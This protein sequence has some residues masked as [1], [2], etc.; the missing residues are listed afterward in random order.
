VN[1]YVLPPEHGQPLHVQISKENITKEP[2]GVNG[3]NISNAHLKT[4]FTVELAK[5][6]THSL[7]EV[8]CA[9]V[10]LGVL[11]DVFWLLCCV[12]TAWR[13]T[14][15]SSETIDSEPP[16]EKPQ[17]PFHATQQKKHEDGYLQRQL[18]TSNRDIQA[19]ANTGEGEPL[20]PVHRFTREPITPVHRLVEEQP[21][22][23]PMS[24]E[25]QLEKKKRRGG[26]PPAC[27]QCGTGPRN[28][29][30]VKDADGDCKDNMEVIDTVKQDEL[31]ELMSS[32]YALVKRGEHWD[33]VLLCVPLLNQNSQEYWL[34]STTDTKGDS[35]IWAA[36]KLVP[37]HFHLLP[38]A[39]VMRS[40]DS[41]PPED[42]D[43]VNG[44]MDDCVH[45]VEE[46]INEA[47][48]VAQKLG[49][50]AE[51]FFAVAGDKEEGIPD[52][53]WRLW[54]GCFAII[55]RGGEWDE[56]LLCEPLL[57]SDWR[58]WLCITTDTNGARCVWAIVQLSDD[59][60][61]HI[62]G[63]DVNERSQECSKVGVSED[64]VNWIDDHARHYIWG[65]VQDQIERMMLNVARPKGWLHKIG[66]D[67][68]NVIKC[69]EEAT[70][71]SDAFAII[72]GRCWT[73][74]LRAFFGAVTCCTVVAP[75]CAIG[76]LSFWAK[77]A[78]GLESTVVA[79]MYAIGDAP[80]RF[81]A[82]TAEGLESVY[83]EI[84]DELPWW[85][86]LAWRLIRAVLGPLVAEKSVEAPN[87]IA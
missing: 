13:R 50:I 41:V 34:C 24:G 87:E 20:T 45:D 83:E 44:I 35:I 60:L 25:K 86:K 54:S 66:Y 51:E 8:A 70:G 5:A 85:A 39:G 37:G 1:N 33:E 59:K 29:N 32:R 46:R 6:D 82:K 42:L 31:L 58:H 57:D 71:I 11:I 65:S 61:Y 9:Q 47:K 78:E 79:R 56:V 12:R 43:K 84:K 23:T 30:V 28:R 38:G 19:T 53:V 14:V 27:Y 4:N 80:L 74:L 76:P 40:Y 49:D 15:T 55:K 77:A 3:F 7:L 17:S 68:W 72:R 75:M 16:F 26:Q 18:D 22:A 67:R 81:W 36:V 48:D 73:T 64:D 2:T 21:C 62:L 52:I 69:D 10:G 63:K